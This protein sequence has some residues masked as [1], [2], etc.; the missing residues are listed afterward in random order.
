MTDKMQ[1]FTTHIR[2]ECAALMAAAVDPLERHLLGELRRSA[3]L[4]GRYDR[5]SPPERDPEGDE[6]RGPEFDPDAPIPFDVTPIPF[7]S[8]HE[9]HEGHVG[10][11]PV[12]PNPN[13]GPEERRLLDLV[14]RRIARRT[15][16]G[17]VEARAAL[18]EV[19]PA[20]AS[21]LDLLPGQLAALIR[22]VIALLTAD[23][24][25][26]DRG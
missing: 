24:G 17:V 20:G 19:L 13:G 14:A 22:F 18:A 21:I 4:L 12:A 15:G 23:F 8:G 26:R 2:C 16:T 5:V 3:T 1:K 25:A 10:V 6:A 9:G 11:S 7:G